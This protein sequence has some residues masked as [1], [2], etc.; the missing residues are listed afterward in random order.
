M[1]E[2][3]LYLIE[4]PSE[5][6]TSIEDYKRQNYLLQKIPLLH[7]G[8]DGVKLG[9]W[10][11]SNTEH[12]YILAGSI[13]EFLGDLYEAKNDI[14]INEDRSTQFETRYIY[15]WRS[16]DDRGHI[17]VALANN[18]V[19]FPSY[20]PSLRGFY[21]EGVSVLNEDTYNKFLRIHF[22]FVNTGDG[23]YLYFQYTY[24]SKKYWDKD[25]VNR[26]GD[27]GGGALKKHTKTFSV[28]GTFNF[29]FPMNAESVIF[30]IMSGG[31]GGGGFGS[32]DNGSFATA[33]GTSKITLNN[34]DITVCDGGNAGNEGYVSPAE[35]DGVGGVTTGKG[36][37]YNGNNS[38]GYKGGSPKDVTNATGGKAGNGRK[39]KG[40]IPD[41]GGG[42]SGACAIVEVLRTELNNAKNIVVTV[43]VKGKAS[44]KGHNA[45]VLATDGE[46]GSVYVEWHE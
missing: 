8:F 45:Q 46:N 44:T 33:G 24:V 36:L 13:V 22:K 14:F 26:I 39:N 3:K 1:S 25:D 37:K 23:E 6:P 21:T 11:E 15:F 19:T 20:N 12:P 7:L 34:S 32:A 30:H 31:G 43:G 4:K 16:N 5:E 42:G 9:N 29:E 18:G 10:N 27:S 40:S 28:P 35:S 38:N 41:A 2:N 17:N